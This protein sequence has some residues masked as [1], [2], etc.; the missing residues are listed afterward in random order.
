MAEVLEGWK[1]FW[2]V[3]TDLGVTTYAEL[4]AYET[5]AE[6]LAE[7]KAARGCDG[8]VIEHGYYPV[9]EWGDRETVSVHLFDDE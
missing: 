7:T 5:E 6:E 8:V 4:C 3:E 1:V 9:D 2:K